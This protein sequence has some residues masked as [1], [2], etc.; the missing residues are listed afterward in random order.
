MS[1]STSRQPVVVGCFVTV[2]LAVLAGG[3]LA[4]G[5]IN[6]T[7]TKKL[8]IKAH[9]ASSAA[10]DKVEKAG[11]SIEILPDT[12]ATAATAA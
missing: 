6:D 2:G 4:I 1:D 10:K 12:I 8:T 5:N 3:I 9:R 11:G 7:F